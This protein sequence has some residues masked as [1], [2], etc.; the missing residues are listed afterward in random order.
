[1]CG[2][3]C[4]LKL[5]MWAAA[6]VLLMASMVHIA[7]AETVTV[8]FSVT[9]GPA[10]HRASGFLHSISTEQPDE[11]VVRHLN[12]RLFRLYAREA[13]TPS[14]YR[15]L[16]KYGAVVQSVISDA[17]GYPGPSGLWPG[18]GSD[19]G[20][21][22]Q[23]VEDLVREADSK[24]L[25]PVW[26][27][28]NEPDHPQFWDRSAEQFFEV[29]KRAV[30]AVRRVNPKSII[31]G[32]SLAKGPSHYLYGFLLSAHAENVLAGHHILA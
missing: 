3:K 4:F 23:L 9:N 27:I 2:E 13:L 7:E 20:R 29:W 1:M 12:P 26:D 30:H 18:D 6:V 31:V 14:L 10:T 15:R 5:G 32:P 19:W 17:Y 16:T 11:Q 8:D 21:W 22:E 25:Q 24:G 28:W